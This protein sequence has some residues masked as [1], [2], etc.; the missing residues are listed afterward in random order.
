MTRCRFL[1]SLPACMLLVFLPAVSWAKAEYTYVVHN[2]QGALGV[3]DTEKNAV[4]ATLHV[5]R[6]AE[7]VVMSHDGAYAYV[8]HDDNVAVIDAAT[9][10]IIGDIALSRGSGAMGMALTPNGAKLY[11]ADFNSN[12]VSVIDTK[13]RVVIAEIRTGFKNPS[14]VAVTSSGLKAYVA[15]QFGGGIL[16]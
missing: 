2:N 9:H 6:N 1:C 11:V 8:T 14:A 16:P 4:I 13:T 5:G 12:S 15:N 7:A 3:I 10:K